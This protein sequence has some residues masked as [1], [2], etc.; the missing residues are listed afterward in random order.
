MTVA[1][2]IAAFLENMGAERG[3]SSHTLV[4][5]GSDLAQF[6]DFLA[7]R[8]IAEPSSITTD[9]A[10]AFLAAL[11]R[12][13]LAPATLT[14]KGVTLKMWAQW[15]CRDG[16]CVEDW[17]ANLEHN[18]STDRRLPT[19]LTVSEFERLL[20]A[21]LEDTPEG[22]RDRAM[23]ELMYGSGLRVSEL[24]S[25]QSTEIDLTS[26]VVRPFGKRA[27]EREVPINEASRSALSRYLSAARP[28]L[29]KNKLPSP[30]LFV[31]D[32]GGPMTRQHFWLL[33]QEYA[34]NARITKH[35][36]PHTLRHSFATHLLSGGADVRSIQ[37]M[38][39]HASVETTQR[40]TR[41]DVAR[42]RVV[43]DKTHPKA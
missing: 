22:L 27:K 8:G 32:H 38:L 26:C 24:V 10:I 35:I 5:Y 37:E 29:L 2:A 18:R 41:V 14:R 19:T 7:K 15:L 43:Y 3:L 33:I 1:A 13:G 6:S 25:L 20:H 21:P 39:G 17:T 12:L 34:L 31:T 23:L 16:I 4:A 28:R 9:H 36:G 40:Y 11:H 42:L 30:A